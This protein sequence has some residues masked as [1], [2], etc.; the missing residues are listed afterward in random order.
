MW[1]IDLKNDLQTIK[2]MGV[3]CMDNIIDAPACGLPPEAELAF[4]QRSGPPWSSLLLRRYEWN[5]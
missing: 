5:S 1:M 3:D 4:P 2:A